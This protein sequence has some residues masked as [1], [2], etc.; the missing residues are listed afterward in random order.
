MSASLYNVDPYDQF[1][2]LASEF[3]S[4]LSEKQLILLTGPLGI[5][6]SE[7]VRLSLKTLGY[8]QEI[9]SPTF[10]LHQMYSWNGKRVDHIDLYRIEKE[11]ELESFGFFELFLRDKGII[12]VEWADKISNHVWPTDWDCTRLDF[13]WKDSKRTLFVS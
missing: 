3:A 12:F 1:Q 2:K 6:K 7:W 8:D 10:V 13:Q 5:G 9:P 4:H 11:D